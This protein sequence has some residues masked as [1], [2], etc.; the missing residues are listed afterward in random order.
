MS[1]L[2]T[3]SVV[4]AQ[5]KTDLPRFRVGATVEVAYQ[6]VEGSKTRIQKFAG[7][8]I[9]KHN[10]VDLNATFTVVKV[11]A[12]QT[13]VT[14]VFALHSPAIVSITVIKNARAKKASLIYAL[15]LKDFKKVKTI[16]IKY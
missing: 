8:V 13:K 4:K 7:L 2:H 15:D 6:I 10:E 3:S 14:R 12:A 1:I 11:A 9:G 5:L 16:N